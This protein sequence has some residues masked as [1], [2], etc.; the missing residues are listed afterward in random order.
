MRKGQTKV[1]P[2]QAKINDYKRFAFTSICIS[3]FFY[4][5]MVLPTEGK[6]DFITY[7]YLFATIAFLCTSGLFFG[8]AIKYKKTLAE[9][10]DDSIQQ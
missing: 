4:L 10:E 1:S 8:I 3:V 6:T 7:G 5:G 2:M 9:Q